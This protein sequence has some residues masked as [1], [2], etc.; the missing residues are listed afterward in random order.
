MRQQL[1]INE[2]VAEVLPQD[3]ERKI[4]A[5]KAAGRKVAMIGDG[6]NDAPALAAADVGM[7]IGAG[8]DVAMESADI[9]LM[10]SDLRDAVTALR[11]SRAVIRNIKQNLFWAFF[12]NVIGPV[13]GQLHITHISAMCVRMPLYNDF[14][15]IAAEPILQQHVQIHGDHVPQRLFA[16]LGQRGAV[17]PKQHI[18][19]KGDRAC[20]GIHLHAGI[21]KGILQRAYDICPDAHNALQFILGGGQLLSGILNLQVSLV[22]LLLG[23]RSLRISLL[24]LRQGSRQLLVGLLNLDPGIFQIRHGGVQLCLGSAQLQ[25]GGIQIRGLLFINRKGYRYN[26]HKDQKQRRHHIGIGLPIAVFRK[27]LP[28]SLSTFH[29]GSSSVQRHKAD[30]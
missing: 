23:Q 3:K 9:V 7:A 30:R 4:S 18:R 28:V 6:I 16:V 29:T 19:G 12:Y 11:L 10:K 21:V 26:Q 1:G 13:V 27:S 14:R 15:N 8:T 17:E 24:Q 2:V 5:L 25:P 20:L 22:Q